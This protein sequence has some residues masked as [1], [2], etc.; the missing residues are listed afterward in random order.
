MYIFFL[1]FLLIIAIF[2]ESTLIHLP[3][4]LIVLLIFLIR[5]GRSWILIFAL[6]SGILLDVLFLRP[7][8]Q[9]SIFLSL[10]LFLVLLY[11]QKYELKTIVFA[12]LTAGIGS[13]IYLFLFGSVNFI[14]QICVNIILA[15]A[16]FV[17][18]SKIE[19][20]TKVKK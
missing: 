7:I 12:V 11:E 8:G 6:F 1:I 3:L 10:F 14:F 9:T 13:G 18:L 2:L 4:T 20:W 15:I 5:L 19:L 16:L 17:I